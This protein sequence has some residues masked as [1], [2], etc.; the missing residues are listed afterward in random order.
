MQCN[1]FNNFQNVQGGAFWMHE[2]ICE[3]VVWKKK[4]I[5]WPYSK[6]KEMQGTDKI[7]HK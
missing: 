6:L 7:I 3:R 5:V 4:L 2:H 1:A